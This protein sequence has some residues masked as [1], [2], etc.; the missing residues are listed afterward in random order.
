MTHVDDA[1][2]GQVPPPGS[3]SE[4][5]Q[6]LARRFDAPEAEVQAAFFGELFEE[7]VEALCLLGP[8]GR[9]LRVNGAFLR[10][11]G[12]ANHECVGRDIDDLILAQGQRASGRQL[13]QEVD[14]GGLVA[15][16]SVRVHRDGTPVDVSI[17]GQPIR[18]RG[19]QIGTYVIYRDISERKRAEASLREAKAAAEA[20]S[21]A[22]TQFLANMSHEIRTPMNAIIGMAD[23]LA[24]TGLDDDQRQYVAIFRSSGQSLLTLINDLLDLSKIEAGNIEIEVIPFLVEEPLTEAI[25]VVS[26]GAHRKGIELV[27]RISP[28]IPPAVGDPLRLKQVLVNLLGNAVKFTTTGEVGV[29]ARAEPLAASLGDGFLLHIAVWDTGCGI[30]ES[31]VDEIFDRFVQADSSTTR[32]FGGSGLGLTIS[33]RLVELMGGQLRV[34]SVV[35]AGSTFSFEIPLMSGPP[36]TAPY[37]G[38]PPDLHGLRALVVDDHPTNRLIMHEMLERWHATVAEAEDGASALLRITEA[39]EAG[40]PYDLVLLDG[41]MPEMDGFEVARRI[42]ADPRMRTTAVLMLTSLDRPGDIARS[43]D[44]NVQAYLVKPIQRDGLARALARVGVAGPPGVLHGEGDATTAEDPVEAPDGTRKVRVLLAE[45][46]EDNQLLV[47]HYVKALPIALILAANGREAVD[48][49]VAGPPF[50][51]ILMDIQMPLMDG[52]EAVRAIREIEAKEGRRPVPIVALTAHALESERAA[53][54]EAGCDAHL[55]KPIRKAELIEA[56][57]RYGGLSET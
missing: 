10:L 6:H 18:F 35:D 39:H 30:P 44:V 21:T 25:H 42:A 15:T 31:K 41:H 56:I 28:D 33:K 48:R 11:F 13:T 23:L 1:H 50:D 17:L 19:E 34:T 14:L 47:H 3:L 5:I 46:V 26:M 2:L 9:I 4:V 20:A 55:T 36:G 54:L 57:R 37:S 52:Y 16:E 7:S 51:L 32:R 38:T 40:Q 22:K 53:I 45:D 29:E 27:A 24:D 43:R 49:F 8:D 12:F